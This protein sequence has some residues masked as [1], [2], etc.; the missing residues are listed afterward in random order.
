MTL[1]G[2]MLAIGGLWGD[3][4]WGK[5]SSGVTFS[6]TAL[7]REPT[8]ARQVL[9]ADEHGLLFML[10]DRMAEMAQLTESRYQ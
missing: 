2:Q 7:H 1:A 8:G 3:M 6:A 10:C 4:S 5:M 9:R